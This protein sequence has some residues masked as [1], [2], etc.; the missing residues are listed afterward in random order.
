MVS[1]YFLTA[2]EWPPKGTKFCDTAV[3]NQL[4]NILNHYANNYMQLRNIE[5]MDRPMTNKRVDFTKNSATTTTTTTTTTKLGHFIR[6]LLSA[7][8]HGT[9]NLLIAQL[10][11]PCEFSPRLSPNFR[12]QP[13]CNPLHRSAPLLSS[14]KISAKA[15]AS[16]SE[17]TKFSRCFVGEKVPGRISDI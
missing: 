5:I 16:T 11:S 15:P 17:W 1:L 3:N 7:D 12:P 14:S 13:C 2:N 10:N 9:T 8:N 6:P 4:G